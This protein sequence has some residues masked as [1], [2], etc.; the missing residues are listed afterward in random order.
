MESIIASLDEAISIADR[1]LLQDSSMDKTVT[2]NNNGS[3]FMAIL[4]KPDAKS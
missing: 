2:L 1:R 3:F 4:F